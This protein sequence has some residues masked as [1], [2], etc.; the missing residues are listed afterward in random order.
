MPSCSALDCTND[1]RTKGLCHKHYN[2]RWRSENLETVRARQ[3]GVDQ[4]AKNLKHNYGLTV[5]EFEALLLAQAGVCAICSQPSRS[6]KPLCVDHCHVT[7]RVRG[8]LCQHCNT[9]IGMMEDSTDRLKK[10][11][12]YLEPAK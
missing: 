11:I 2:A 8:L 10:A 12:A 3:R 9:A 1:A 6:A 4:R 5:E 7:G